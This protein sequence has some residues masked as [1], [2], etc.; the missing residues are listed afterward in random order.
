M[1]HL[2]IHVA[3]VPWLLALGLA[4]ICWSQGYQHN[5]SQ[6]WDFTTASSPLGWSAIVPLKNFGIQSGA[7][8]FTA[9]QQI[10]IVCSAFLSA[11]AAP[12]QLVEIVMRSDVGGA[13]KVFWAPAMGSGV[14]GGFKPGDES[15]F[16]MVG[17][18]AFHHYYLPINTSSAA[19]IYQLRLDV[20]TGAT[21]S[22]Q[23]IELANLVAPSGYGGSPF[24]QFGSDGN[25]LGWIPYQGVVDMGV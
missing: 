10:N 1:T 11:P 23:S 9:T 21:V 15:D 4:S 7:L 24:W 17:D 22:I 5:V 20:P 8:N 3:V 25:S 6:S 13:S 19:T 14:C 16:T 12:M 18:G 2:R